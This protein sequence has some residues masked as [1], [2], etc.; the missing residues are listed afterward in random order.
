MISS[1]SVD[2]PDPE[3]PLM[4]TSPVSGIVSLGIFRLCSRAWV[5]RS[6]GMFVSDGVPAGRFV[7]ET[8]RAACSCSQV[9]TAASSQ[10]WR[11]CRRRFA[12]AAR[13]ATAFSAARSSRERGGIAGAIGGSAAVATSVATKNS[14]CNARNAP[15]GPS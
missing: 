6:A 1:S 15:G 9:D 12:A 14:G 5:M 7:R 10:G 11:R 13:S 3:T 8:S 4:T 2:F